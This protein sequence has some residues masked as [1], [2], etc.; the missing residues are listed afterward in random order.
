MFKKLLDRYREKKNE[1]ILNKEIFKL[2]EL[3][4]GE[5][6]LYKKCEDIGLGEVEHIY[7]EIKKFAFFYE[8]D[9]KKYRHIIS[10]QELYVLGD[11][12]SIIGDYAVH[13]LRKFE[14][15]FPRFIRKHN[16]TLSSKVSLL[17]L[18]QGEEN[19]NK[20][21]APNQKSDELFNYRYQ[22]SLD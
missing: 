19:M 2:D 11:Y 4:V 5:I 3:Y 18:I 21:L 16:L 7:R 8:C 14:E 6:V 20:E 22:D 17:F 13:N 9:Y 12:K 1:K 10:G 15:V